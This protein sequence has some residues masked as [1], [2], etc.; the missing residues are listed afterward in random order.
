M[1]IESVF[2]YLNQTSVKLALRNSRLVPAYQQNRLSPQ[3]ER[4]GDSPCAIIGTKTKFLHIR[5]FRTLQRIH[6]RP[7]Q[8]WTKHR[9]LFDQSED[10]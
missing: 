1:F 2:R 9:Q 10:L 3:I 4:K 8:L 7:A 6:L 5:V